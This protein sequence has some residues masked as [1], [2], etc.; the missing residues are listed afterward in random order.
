MSKALIVA[1]VR[2]PI[3]K[4]PRGSLRHTRPDALAAFA[5]APCWSACPL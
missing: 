2:I 1:E 5:F 3:G 4:A